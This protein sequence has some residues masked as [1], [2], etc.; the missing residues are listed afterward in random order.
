M[1]NTKVWC[2]LIN[3][4]KEIDGDPFS[5]EV[6]SAD[7]ID[8]LKDKIKLKNKPDF[9]SIPARHLVVWKCQD[10]R[11]TANTDPEDL[12]ELLKNFNFEAKALKPGEKV[13]SDFDGQLF[14]VRMKDGTYSLQPFHLELI[15]ME[16]FNRLFSLS[17][18][19]SAI[20]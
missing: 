10:R 18:Y 9:D 19:Q 20:L 17:R 6:S 3:H 5:V 12:Q 4:A 8:N 16:H 7:T 13:T 11:M 14:I 2:L 15:L 1:T